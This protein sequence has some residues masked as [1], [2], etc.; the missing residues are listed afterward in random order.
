MFKVGFGQRVLGLALCASLSAC[1]GEEAAVATATAA[2]GPVQ[3]GSTT[4]RTGG[5][6]RAK[7]SKCKDAPSSELKRF[8]RES[9][10]DYGDGCSNTVLT[11][12]IEGG[13]LNGASTI[14]LSQ[15]R[16]KKVNGKTTPLPATLE[17]LTQS[18]DGWTSSLLSD[19]EGVVF[20]KAI[21]HDNGI[22]SI[23]AGKPK[24]D[25]KGH[26]KFWTQKD[27]EW[28]AET[29]WSASW[30]GDK[31]RL[32]DFEI[33]DVDGDGEDEIVIATHDNGVIAVLDNA[34]TDEELVV[35]ELDPKVNTYVHEIE[36]GD[37]DGDGTPEFFATPSDP[38]KSKDT[39]AGEVVMYRFQAGEYVRSVVDSTTSTH[40]KEILASDLDGDGV[41]EVFSAVEAQKVA[42][43]LKS[44][45]EIRQFQ[46]EAGAPSGHQVV[47]TI[48]DEQL[49]FMV[50]HDFDGDGW[51][52]LL[53]AP[54]KTGL[55]LIDSED[56]STYT[57]EHIIKGSGGF[58]HSL[59]IFDLDQDGSFEAYVADDEYSRELYVYRWAESG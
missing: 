21:I 47:A 10:H 50:A 52:E 40:A 22:L 55:Y 42:G 45:V 1:G 4:A 33:G 58:E 35:Q 46:F 6:S 51:K 9:L 59:N 57:T 36:L 53:V 20:H 11:W 7:A 43:Q 5:A 16:F 48:D 29:L 25:Q 31:Q 3:S 19:E 24:T 56:G 2:K 37:V 49:R 8:E 14:L 38:N 18:D 13:T 30:D 28:S 39:Q 32:R 26:L 41:S 27:G 34:L 15:A 17:L 23:S 54:M 44:K 12:Y